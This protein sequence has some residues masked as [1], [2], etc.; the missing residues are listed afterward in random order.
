LQGGDSLIEPI[1]S[2]DDLINQFRGNEVTWLYSLKWHDL[3]PSEQRFPAHRAGRFT[4]A[5]NYRAGPDCWRKIANYTQN[6]DHGGANRRRKLALTPDN[7]TV[8]RAGV[9]FAA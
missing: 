5:Q 7:D 4:I 2:V 6:P 1:D 8:Q 3:K 9:I